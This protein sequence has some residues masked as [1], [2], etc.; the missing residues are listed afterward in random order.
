MKNII[1]I[2]LAMI[3]IILGIGTIVF[4]SDSKNLFASFISPGGGDFP[5]FWGENSGWFKNRQGTGTAPASSSQTTSNYGIR[6][7]GNLVSGYLWGENTGWV[8]L[9]SEAGDTISHGVTVG[10]DSSLNGFAWSELGG[11]LSFD[12]GAAIYEPTVSADTWTGYAWSENIGWVSL[13]QTD[14][15]AD[16][17]GDGL[18]DWWEDNYACTDSNSSD[19]NSDPDSDNLTNLQ[20][21]QHFVD[22]NQ[23]INPC[24]AD[25]DDDSYT[26]KTEIDQGT[27]PIDPADFPGCCDVIVTPTPSTSD[28]T[29][30]IQTIGGGSTY[31]ARP[32][33]YRELSEKDYRLIQEYGAIVEP[34]Q[35]LTTF[36]R[37]APKLSTGPFADVY[38]THWAAKII[39]YAWN[40]NII[41]EATTLFE[42]E[43]NERY[44]W[45]NS[46]ISRAEAVAFLIEATY[47]PLPDPNTI[48][49]KPFPDVALNWWD[50]P[51]VVAGERAGWVWGYSDGTFKPGNPV[52][53]SEFLKI[54][55]MAF[56]LDPISDSNI[57]LKPFSDV[58]FGYWDTGYIKAASDMNLIFGYKDNT[59]HP[60]KNITRAEAITIILRA[61]GVD[62]TAL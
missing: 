1:K 17:D 50:T 26:D 53:R 48:K 58:D 59:F 5:Y 51:Y 10:G 56:G 14:P 4:Q 21:Y 32:V 25:T 28:D 23:Q 46:D 20:E 52:T 36:G 61:L 38:D 24:L 2:T 37:D 62:E 6:I 27:N 11:W 35:W 39:T 31:R 7:D 9:R 57:T 41:P 54:L 33:S 42:D 13:I 44:F 40:N 43:E 8:S 19:A 45:P 29:Q 55:F 15:N 12:H 18:P 16:A 3:A 30:I 49:S 22:H 34:S 60:R 47:L